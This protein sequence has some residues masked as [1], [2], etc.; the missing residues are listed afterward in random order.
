M[1][2]KA[3]EIGQAQLFSD[4]VLVQSALGSMENMDPVDKIIHDFRTGG[5]HTTT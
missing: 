2:P 1:L 4:D 3:F 5:H